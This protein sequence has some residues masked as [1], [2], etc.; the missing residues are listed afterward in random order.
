MFI[1]SENLSDLDIQK[2]RKLQQIQGSNTSLVTYLI[3]A[4]TDL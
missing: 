1:Q 4:G 2:L 3:P